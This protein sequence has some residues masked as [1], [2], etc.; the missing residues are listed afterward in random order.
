[1]VVAVLGL[2]MLSR[3]S[4]VG[5]DATSTSPCTS[6]GLQS[7]TQAA[8]SSISQTAAVNLAEPTLAQYSTNYAASFDSVHFDFSWTQSCSVHV[9]DV[10]VDYDLKQGGVTT[11]VL[12]ITL[13][14][15]LTTVLG[16]T[17]YP[18]TF[19][20]VVEDSNN[21]VGPEYNMTSNSKSLGQSGAYWYIPTVQSAG[22][23]GECATTGCDFAFWVGQSVYN[24]TYGLAHPTSWDDSQTGTDSMCSNSCDSS[25]Y[26][27]YD[28]WYEFLPGGSTLAM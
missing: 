2:L 14:P 20:G 25:S 12:E 4:P 3:V 15:S 19:H 26:N 13:D 16:A 10:S 17:L 18:A 8:T 23:T 28:V 1:M 21:Y 27:S 5:A 9:R 11:N 24:A 7:A 22:Y 6:S